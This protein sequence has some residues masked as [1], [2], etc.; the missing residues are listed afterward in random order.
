MSR[1]TSAKQLSLRIL[2]S[3]DLRHYASFCR[4]FPLMKMSREWC[5]QEKFEKS[6]ARQE[7]T[8]MSQTR[9][10]CVCTATDERKAGF[11]FAKQSSVL[12]TGFRLS[13]FR[14]LFSMLITCRTSAY[15]LPQRFS[16]WLRCGGMHRR[17]HCSD[18]NMLM[19]QME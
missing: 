14:L 4:D 2:V 5:E 6:K 8:H 9:L 19:R 10:L 11:F 17:E 12:V 15:S 16:R 7:E 13:G 1:E 3:I 18:A